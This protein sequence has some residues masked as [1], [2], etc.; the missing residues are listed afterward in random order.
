[1]VE[2][3]LDFPPNIYR[4]RTQDKS[5]DLIR[6]KTTTEMYT[7]RA[8]QTTSYEQAKLAQRHHEHAI[9]QDVLRRGIPY[10]QIPV[11]LATAREQ[12]KPCM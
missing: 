2:L 4:S 10:H 11:I 12:M 8:E 3:L 1:M 9:L 5:L 6:A 7:T